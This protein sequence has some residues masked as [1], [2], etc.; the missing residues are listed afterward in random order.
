MSP[1]PWKPRRGW[2]VLAS[3]PAAIYTCEPGGDFALTYL[4][5]NVKGLVGWEARDFLADASFWLNHLHPEDRPRILAQLE[6][7]WPEDHQSLEYRFQTKDGAYLWMH[8][9]FRLVR[10]PDGKPV[11]IA[12]A[13]WTSRHANRWKRS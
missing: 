1:S 2:S 9:E 3:G 6:L 11:E 12:G 13:G 8:D 10:D 5:G 4:S 7:P